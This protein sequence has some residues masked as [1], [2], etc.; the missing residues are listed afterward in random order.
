MVHWW[1]LGH[2]RKEVEGTS[3][4]AGSPWQPAKLYCNR[5]QQAR[6]EC[7][8]QK[9]QDPNLKPGARELMPS[10]L[11]QSPPPNLLGTRGRVGRITSF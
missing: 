9:D 8:T 2:I 7:K 3:V 5:T 1:V 6:R 10:T 11:S 4:G